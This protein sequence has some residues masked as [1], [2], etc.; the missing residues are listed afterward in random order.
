MSS[1]HSPAR[2]NRRGRI[3]HNGGPPLDTLEDQKVLAIKQWCDLNSF[4]VPTG[5]RVIAS[6]EG[7]P[8]VLLSARRL[9]VRVGDNRRWQESRI[10]D[11][12]RA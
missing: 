6:G 3:G 7:P 10:R 5:K 1:E 4:S 2:Q 9:G 11:G 12:G 8:V